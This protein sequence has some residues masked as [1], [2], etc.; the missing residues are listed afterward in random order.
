MVSA[1]VRYGRANKTRT[2]SNLAYQSVP[3]AHLYRTIPPY[4]GNFA[5]CKKG[6]YHESGGYLDET[7]TNK[8]AHAIIDFLAGKDVGLGVF[9]QGGK[10]TVSAGVRIA[11]FMASSSVTLHARPDVIWYND[12]LQVYG[13]YYTKKF[14]GIIHNNDH[15]HAFEGDARSKRSFRGV[16]P[17]IS[18][19]GSVPVLLVNETETLSFDWGANG[20]LLFGRRRASGEHHES[21]HYHGGPCHGSYGNCAYY[22][23]NPAPFDRRKSVIVPN[24]GGFAG[25]SVNYLNA[26]VSFGYR[27]DEFFGAI[28]TGWDKEHSNSVGFFGPYANLS[29]GF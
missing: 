19:N 23:N 7:V 18:W 8:D 3:F 15:F 26:K 22:S 6:F 24:L 5:C 13:S 14:P 12:T 4:S 25:V 11:Q 20:A 28:D 9:G 17:T 1:S 16:G 21:G 29:I 10:S 27:V 2:F